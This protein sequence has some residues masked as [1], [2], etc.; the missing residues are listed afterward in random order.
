MLPIACHAWSYNN[1]SLENTIGTIARLG[2][3]YIDLGMGPHLD[4]MNL[5]RH[6]LGEAARLKQLL[7]DFAL[8]LTDLYLLLPEINAPD[9]SL[10]EE[11]LMQFESLLPFAVELGTPGIT[12][13]PG[14]LQEDGPDHSL[15]RAVPAFQKILDSTESTDLRISFEPQPDSAVETPEQ[16][17]NLLEAVPGLSL[18]L[19]L[20]HMVAKNTH[21]REVRSL[22]EYT[23]HLHLRQARPDHIQAPFHKGKLEIERLLR[24]LVE[25]DYHGALTIEYT[26]DFTRYGAM[27]IGISQE[28]VKMRDALVVARQ[29]VLAEAER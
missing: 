7:A 3:R 16:A 26:S 19:D 20:G 28:V 1:L 2:F 27:E 25:A 15:A 21:W 22:F 11:Q 29:L 17:R 5:V 23:A 8:E 6:P 10:R 13:S 12:L 9:A 18:T 14:R 4:E 24:D